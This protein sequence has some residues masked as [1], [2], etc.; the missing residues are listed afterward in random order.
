MIEKQYI[1]YI[2]SILAGIFILLT[3]GKKYYKGVM[4]RDLKFNV[5]GGKRW[6]GKPVMIIALRNFVIEDIFFK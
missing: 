1:N 3:S 6:T 5:M 4:K 2:V